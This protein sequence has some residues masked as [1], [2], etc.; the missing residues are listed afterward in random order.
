[1]TD[2]DGSLVD[3]TSD[4]GVSYLAACRD[5][6][7]CGSLRCILF[8]SRTRRLFFPSFFDLG[9]CGRRGSFQSGGDEEE[10]NWANGKLMSVWDLLVDDE[11]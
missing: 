3:Y 9:L 1:M 4:D 2:D 7:R 8:R 10:V 5:M 6:S 11:R